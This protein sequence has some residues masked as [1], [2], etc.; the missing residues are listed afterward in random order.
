MPSQVGHHLFKRDRLATA[1]LPKAVW[2]MCHD[3]HGYWH[4]HPK[5]FRAEA[6]RIIG[7]VK[8]WR[9][10]LLSQTVVKNVDFKDIRAKLKKELEEP[11]L[12]D[13]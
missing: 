9:L 12:T 13:G 2:G 4:K 5:E 11:C 7:Y 6:M 1:F 8:Y 3:H 10:Y